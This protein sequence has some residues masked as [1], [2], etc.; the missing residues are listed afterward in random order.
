MAF[1]VIDAIT[2]VA[3]VWGAVLSSVLAIREVRR[4]RPRLRVFC[5]FAALQAAPGPW[6]GIEI[7]AVNTGERA[8]AVEEAGLRLSD[9]S[10]VIEPYNKLGLVSLPK[11]LEEGDSVSVYLDMSAVEDGVRE[12][13]DDSGARLAGVYVRDAEG[14]R[15]TGR[16]P[17]ALL[18]QLSQRRFRS[19]STT[20]AHSS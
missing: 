20:A 1:T 14:R 19:P 15:Y 5:S 7:K 12:A 3:A 4:D 8:V 11:R 16:T 6:R 10:K 13:Y 2:A 18:P 17:V 9:G